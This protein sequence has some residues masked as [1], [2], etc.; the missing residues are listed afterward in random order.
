MA[1]NPNN[2]WPPRPRQRTPQVALNGNNGGA[3]RRQYST[4][5]SEALLA[6]CK[7]PTPARI[8]ALNS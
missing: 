2:R 8:T 1:L 4:I 5:G 7:M 6:A 3:Q